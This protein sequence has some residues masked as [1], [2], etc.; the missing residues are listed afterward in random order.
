MFQDASEQL[1]GFDPHF[2]IFHDLMPFKVQDILLVS[3]RYDAFIMEEDGSLATRLINEY[4]GLNLSKPP[5]ITRASS[6]GEALEILGLKKFDMVITMPY[7]GGMDAFALGAAIKK[8][9]PQVPVILVAHNL[10]STFPEKIDGYGVDKTFIWCCEADLLLAIIKNVEDHHNVDSDT[11]RAMVRVLIYV[12]DSPLYRSLFLPLIYREVVR[13]TQS[14]LDESLNERHRLLRMR[15]RPRILMATNY[16]E[17]MMLYQAYKPYVFGIISDARFRRG[18]VMADEA[19]IDFLRF[20]RTE[21]HDLPLLVVSNEQHNRWV[22]ERIPAVFLDKNSPMIK[23]ELHSFFLEHLGFGDF[24]FRLPDETAIG[25]AANLHEFEKQLRVIPEVSLRYHTMRNHF[26]N[27]VMARAEVTLARRL[28]KDYVLNIDDLQSIREDLLYK[29]HSLRKLRQKGVVVK[30]SAEDYDS[31]IMDFVKIGSGS[32]GGKA[33]GIAFMW[34]RMQESYRENSVLNSHTITIPKTCVITADG[35]NAFVEANNLFFNKPMSDE[36]VADIF[37]DAVLPAWFRQELRS[38]LLKCDHPLSV[39]SSSLL[40]DAHFKPYAGLYSTYFLANNHADFNERLA[41][42]ESAVKLVYASTWFESPLAFS[43]ATAHGRE[44]S[45][46]VII[47][48]LAGGRYGDYWYPA[49]SG[50]AQSRNFY[51]VMDMRADE[52]VAHIALGIGKTVVEGG[53]TLWFSPARAKKLMQFSTVENML[54]TS[55]R[56][57]YALDMTSSC[58]HRET[59]NL[60]LREIHQAENELP[61][62]MLASTYIAEEERVRDTCL[63]GQKIMTFAPILKYSGYPLAEILTELLAIGKEGMGGEVEIEFAVHLDRDLAKSVFY[64]LQIRPMVTG[65]ELIDVEICDHE[66]GQ[67]VCYVGRSL[68]HG[69]YGDIADIVYVNPATF[70]PAKT[71]EAAQEIGVMNRALRRDKRPFLLVGPGRWGSADPWLGIPVQWSDISGV[72]A[73]IE[74]RGK[75]IRA[76]PSQGTHFFQNITSLGIPYLTLDDNGERAPGRRHR[77]FLDWQWLDRQSVVEQGE[78]VR[79]VRLDAPLTLKCDGLHSES[80]IL[81]AGGAPCR[82]VCKLKG[83]N[84]RNQSIILQGEC[85]GRDNRSDQGEGPGAT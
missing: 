36:E 11:Q 46:A 17:A 65:G 59:S 51:P 44:D 55:Q 37:L 7:L 58:L 53:K 77:D 60:V 79:Q 49:V 21:I 39:R 85:S 69:S 71:R 76:D 32:M 64:F 74:V 25:S 57:F 84:V 31:D 62:T 12:E 68:G 19:G 14:V 41:Q 47:Q 70:N 80:V 50:V 30:F 56:Q 48:E 13:Q 26:S 45:M 61:V 38:F 63:P 3:S 8:I 66:I 73:I 9:Q 27:W 83:K 23:E 15:A 82:M 22:A 16:E 24:I 33:R 10:R 81:Q 29:V 4:H 78:Y 72:A 2:K 54:K 5:K 43:K 28:H 35:F 18:G 75:T 52:G 20:V 1:L 42:L 34:A 40:E 6:A 67:A